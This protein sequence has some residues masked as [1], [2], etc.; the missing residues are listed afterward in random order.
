MNKEQREAAD[1]R[2]LEEHRAR[3]NREALDVLEY[4]RFG[5]NCWLIRMVRT[6]FNEEV[7]RGAI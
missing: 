2:I 6:V 7:N 1:T 3:L 4:Q 5:R